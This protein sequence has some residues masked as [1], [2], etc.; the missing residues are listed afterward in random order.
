L[1]QK[2]SQVARDAVAETLPSAGHRDLAD[3]AIVF[4]VAS[5]AWM[6]V[7]N[8]ISGHWRYAWLAYLSFAVATAWTAWL[9][10]HRD[11]QD[12]SWVLWVDLAL[13]TYMMLVSALVVP[14]QAVS[15]AARLFFATAYPL[16]TT[17]MWGIFRHVRGGLF[18]AFVLS[19]ALAL[20]RPLNGVPYH[21]LAPFVGVANGA[22]YFFMAG[23]TMGA[24]R[25]SIDRAA[26]AVQAAVD[27]VLHEQD[28]AAREQARAAQLAARLDMRDEIHDGVVQDLGLLRRSLAEQ[29]E[30]HPDDAAL[31]GLDRALNHAIARLRDVITRERPDLPAGM[32]SLENWLIDTKHKLPGLDTSISLAVKVQLPTASARELCAAVE[33]ALR[34]IE[35]HATT[36]AAWIFAEVDDDVLKLQVVDHGSGFSRDPDRPS[37][38]GHPGIDAM[39]RRLESI[40]GRM[41]IIS[42]PGMGTTV[43]F[44]LPIGPDWIIA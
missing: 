3:G 4:R 26:S 41:G 25:R 39:R 11:E 6:I 33:Q 30:Q 43:E 42:A 12:R 9:S 14:N 28:L 19:A 29:I 40:G 32:A 16:S 7:F 31:P 17:I 13:S 23:G 34:N 35:Q 22:A 5:L 27:R 24:I 1:R 18:A 44:Q 20:T 10:F 21:G 36:D 37:A 15:K 2:E 8:V 38:A